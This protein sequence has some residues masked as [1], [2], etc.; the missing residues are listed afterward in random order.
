MACSMTFAAPSNGFGAKRC[1]SALSGTDFVKCN[2][3]VLFLL[4][5]PSPFS[6]TLVHQVTARACVEFFNVGRSLVCPDDPNLL[7]MRRIGDDH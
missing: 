5:L 4:A 7:L 6:T 1:N 2:R 3:S